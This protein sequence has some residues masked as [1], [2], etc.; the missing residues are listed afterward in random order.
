MLDLPK[1]INHEQPTKIVSHFFVSVPE[2]RFLNLQCYHPD[3][4]EGEDIHRSPLIWYSEDCETES[5]FLKQESD[6]I[7]ATTNSLIE[8][9]LVLR[10]NNT[11]RKIINI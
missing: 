8:S 3:E 4:I 10:K 7:L 11:C 2:D 5:D 9:L 6:E 1:D